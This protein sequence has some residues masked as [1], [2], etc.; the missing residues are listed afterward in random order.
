M[1]TD[2]NNCYVW[3]YPLPVHAKA[4][5]EKQLKDWLNNGIVE[6]AKTSAIFHSPLL[7]V[8]KKDENDKLAVKL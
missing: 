2:V 1:K 8:P 5:I 7:A 6:K 3:Q 4:E